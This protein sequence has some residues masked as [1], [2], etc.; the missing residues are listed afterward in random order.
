MFGA[1]VRGEGGK[2]VKLE[3]N[4]VQK[5]KANFTIALETPRLSAKAALLT[6]HPPPFRLRRRAL[7]ATRL[8][9]EACS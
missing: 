9:G 5:A 4:A 2:V 1:I 6:L 8:K 3:T 7:P